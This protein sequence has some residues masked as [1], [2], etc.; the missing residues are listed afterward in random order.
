[1]SDVT[2]NCLIRMY[3]RIATGNTHCSPI[4]W[5]PQKQECLGAA[6]RNPRSTPFLCVCG[7]NR[8]E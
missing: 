6:P 1:M 2:G 8:S 5:K 7:N 3:S 4:I